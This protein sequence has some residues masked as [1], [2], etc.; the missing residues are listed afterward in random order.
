MQLSEV[1]RPAAPS[2]RTRLAATLATGAFALLMGASGVMFLV[3]P[4]SLV[5][6]IARLGY[7]SYVIRLI[8]V[9][10][11]AGIAALVVPVAPRLREWAYAGFAFLLGLALA[12]HVLS[13]DTLANTT[14]PIVPLALLVASYRL[15]AERAR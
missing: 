15:R 5:E 14:H 10:K 9:A 11:L 12:S 3:S 1:D 13:G 8:G 6:S 7:P 2:S 4:P